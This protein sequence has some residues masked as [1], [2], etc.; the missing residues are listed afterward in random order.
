MKRLTTNDSNQTNVLSNRVSAGA[1]LNGS[2]RKLSMKYITAD[3]AEIADEN[4]VMT[5]WVARPEQGV[6][7]RDKMVRNAVTDRV[8]HMS[9]TTER[10]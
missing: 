3:R 1:P 2:L 7:Q 5:V 9:H 10:S 6:S 4:S 8:F